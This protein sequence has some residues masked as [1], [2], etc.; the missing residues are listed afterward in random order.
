[1]NPKRYG[2]DASTRTVTDLKELVEELGIGHLVRRK[3]AKTVK[4]TDGTP[5]DKTTKGAYVRALQ[6]HFLRDIYGETIPLSVWDSFKY[7]PMLPTATRKHLLHKIEAWQSPHWLFEEKVNGYRI[8]LGAN[9]QGHCYS[10]SRFLSDTDF[11][12]VRHLVMQQQ[13]T[14]RF[15]ADCELRSTD[16]AKLEAVLYD[17]GYPVTDA[18]MPID[19]LMAV[20]DELFI[21]IV[22]AEPGLIEYVVL[23]VLELGDQQLGSQPYLTRLKTYRE[24]VLNA[25]RDAG[26]NAGCPQQARGTSP[27]E[28]QEFYYR[29]LSEGEEGVVAKHGYSL[30]TPGRTLDWLKFKAMPTPDSDTIDVAVMEYKENDFAVVGA[31][32]PWETE[33]VPFTEVRIPGGESVV[34]LWK[35]VELARADGQWVVNRVRLHKKVQDCTVIPAG[36]EE[37]LDDPSLQS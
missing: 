32:R 20:P 24:P 10:F 4:N 3:F 2:R 29:M 11:L 31:H 22:S 19:V 25:I 21:E 34:P 35:V 9:R 33:I 28:K 14:T 1:M 6:E 18:Y 23:D 13:P 16:A 5:K 27:K 12:P 36:Y 17:L 8:L 30:Y 15:L 37:E 26:L 7:R